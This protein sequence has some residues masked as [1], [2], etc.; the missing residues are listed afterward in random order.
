MLPLTLLALQLLSLKQ[1]P[2]GS[3]LHIRLTTTVGSYAS[4][5]GMA[6]RA[7]L[8]APVALGD[9]IL[10]PAG[11]TLSGEVSEVKRVGLGI[12]H[13]TA[14]LG[15]DFD[16]VTFPDGTGFALATRLRQVDN[17]REHVAKDGSIMGIRTTSSIAYR[18]SGYIR[19]ALCW[20]LHARLAFWAVRTL[21]VQVPE[22]EIYYP[23]GSELTL[24]LTEP[25]LADPQPEAI[26]TAQITWQERGD[27]DHVIANI[28]D[29]A[30][31]RGSNRPSDLVNM[32]FVGSREQ[33]S[34]AFTAAGWTETSAASMRSRI[35]GIRAVAEVHGDLGAPM[36]TLLVNDSRPDMSWQ[37][38]LNDVAKR[39]HIRLWKQSDTWDG[40]EVW[41][42]AAT[43]DVSYAFLRPGRMFTHEIEENIDHERDKIAHDLEF[44]N[45]TEAVELW[46]RPGFPRLA[47]N[48][49]GDL[50]SSDARLAVVRLNDCGS[51]RLT[52][53]GDSA[54]VRAH[55]G[56]LQRFVRRQIL[57]VRN[58]FYR[59]NMI[60][61]SYEGTRWVV[62]MIRKHRQAPDQ[63]D[64]DFDPSESVAHSTFNK[65][66]NSSWLR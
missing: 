24:A 51:P 31:T 15:L 18:A 52:T 17:S 38:S 34:A 40:R 20:E 50:M 59:R 29:R 66:R 41:I 33:V 2:A 28:P 32:L 27:L 48:A 1:A 46:D 26:D 14:S 42:G 22:P 11:S 57:S 62:L 7:V 10:I 12:V 58:D 19:T 6:V 25:F 60:W 23:A 16:H 5:P 47:M 13:E 65:V 54:A 44:T 49:T 39:H 35:K 43:R 55:G 3:T 4:Q 56:M 61:R 30:Y 36:S 64:T 63:M 37:K 8:I 21:L 53:S 9:D 45:C